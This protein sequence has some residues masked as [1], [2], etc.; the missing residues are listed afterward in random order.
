MSASPPVA[1]AN[2]PG[3]KVSVFHWPT[4]REKLGEPGFALWTYW[5]SIRAG[6]LVPYRRDFDPMAIVRQL[7]IISL[8]ERV[9]ALQWPIRLVGTEIVNR[10]GELTGRN[11]IDLVAPEQRAEQDRLLTDQ[12][13][14]PCGSV[15]VRTNVRR[16]GT[17]YLV[18][19]VT[20]P[21][22]RADGKACMLISTN[23]EVDRDMLAPRSALGQMRIAERRFIDIGAGKPPGLDS[24]AA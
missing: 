12:L 9:S 3:A 17:G 19:T 6:A 10:S 22:R 5:S 24:V 4:M 15:G 20:L 14:H 7:P 18:R 11:L 1:L 13:E 2:K 23:E 8:I 21:L 16:S